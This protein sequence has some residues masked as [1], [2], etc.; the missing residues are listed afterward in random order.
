MMA[1]LSFFVLSLISGTRLHLALNVIQN[2]LKL[3]KMQCQTNN[4]RCFAMQW[5]SHT[6][7]AVNFV[8]KIN[9]ISSIAI[10]TVNFFCV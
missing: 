7:I 1:V 9:V 5:T 6:T 2:M 10:T 3:T 8:I 4:Y